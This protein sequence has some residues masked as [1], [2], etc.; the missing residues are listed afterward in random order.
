MVTR[1]E[2]GGWII[3]KLSDRESG[4]ESFYSKGHKDDYQNMYSL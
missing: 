1:W 3:H 4:Q 2:A